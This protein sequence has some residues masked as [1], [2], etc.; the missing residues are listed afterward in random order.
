MTKAKDKTTDRYFSVP[1]ILITS[2]KMYLNEQEVSLTGDS[3]RVYIYMRDRYLFFSGK[4]KHYFEGAEV[5][6]TA[7][8]M[9]ERTVR[10]AIKDFEKVG[11]I[12]SHGKVKRSIIRQV[13][14]VYDIEWRFD[15][16]LYD[17]NKRKENRTKT[18]STPEPSREVDWEDYEETGIP[19]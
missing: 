13:H 18:Q 1:M 7:L 11:L 8:K 16:N 15:S 14:D 10:R 12:T 6:A 2:S 9:N 5:L 4:G 3:V 19:F 17:A